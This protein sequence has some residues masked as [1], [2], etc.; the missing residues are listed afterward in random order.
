[1]QVVGSGRKLLSLVLFIIWFKHVLFYLI[2]Y[3]PRSKLLNFFAIIFGLIAVAAVLSGTGQEEGSAPYVTFPSN[4]AFFYDVPQEE[5]SPMCNADFGN[6]I[7]TDTASSSA[8]S[9]VKYLADYTFLCESDCH[10]IVV[11]CPEWLLT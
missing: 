6:S 11:Y 5:V 1:M 4:N 7:N 8:S 9:P 10:M 3:C 2:C